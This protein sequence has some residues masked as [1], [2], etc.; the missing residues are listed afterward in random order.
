M[1]YIDA[2]YALVPLWG[3][4][5]RAGR[6]RLPGSAAPTADG[7]RR[8]RHALAAQLEHRSRRRT[9]SGRS[10]AFGEAGA[11]VA[12][13]T[14][15]SPWNTRP[16]D[17]YRGL[18]V[19][20]RYDHN[21][22]WFEPDG[23]LYPSSGVP[24]A[25]PIRRTVRLRLLGHPRHPYMEHYGGRRRH[26]GHA[27]RHG[28]TARW[29]AVPGICYG[30]MSGYRGDDIGGIKAFQWLL[31]PTDLSGDPATAD[32]SKAPDVIN[33][34][35]GSANPT[36]DIFRPII[37][38]LRQAGT[39][40]VFA[41]G[42][43]SAGPGSI[44]SPTSIPEAITVGATDSSDEVTYFSGQGPSF[45]S[46]SRNRVERAGPVCAL[47][48]RRRV[49]RPRKEAARPWPHPTWPGLMRA[50]IS[51]DLT[52]GV[53]LRRG[54]VGTLHDLHRGGPGANRDGR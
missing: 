35:W 29:I 14:A 1:A 43:P 24:G 7:H 36:S 13:S 47:V 53:R 38:T 8:T 49:D 51:A 5:E 42:N 23:R 21:Y 34:S 44:G 4:G 50:V 11:V 31:C 15:V 25:Q 33:N 54:R 26:A 10:W 6:H 28:A 30:T 16:C 12:A 32:C 39:A 46:V 41:S 40:A 3:T 45:L 18:L 17:A 20:G 9:G 19:D 22:N 2:N 48:G 52:D 27:G 37:Q